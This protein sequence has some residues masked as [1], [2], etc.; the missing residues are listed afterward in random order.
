MSTYIT[1]SS[2]YP[3]N[4]DLLPTGSTSPTIS[5]VLDEIRDGNG[6][7]I[8]SGNKITAIEVNSIYT[9]IDKV[10]NVLGYNP[11]GSFADVS[12]RLNNMQFSGSLAFL[13]LSGG[14]IFGP[15]DFISGSTLTVTNMVGDNLTTI[16]SGN[17]NIYSSGNIGLAST[18]NLTISVAN[19]SITGLALTIAGSNVVMNGN[20]SNTL[21]SSVNQIVLTAASTSINSSIIPLTGSSVD[22]G[23]TGSF[24]NNLYV[25]NIISTG[26]G[27]GVN[28]YVTQSGSVMHGNLQFTGNAGIILT[29]GSNIT[30]IGSG[31]NNLGDSNNPFSGI[32][33]KVLHASFISGLSPVTFLSDIILNPGSTL[34]ASGTGV[35]IGSITN[36]IDTIYAT[37]IVGATGLDANLLVARSGSSMFGNLTIS[38]NANIVLNSGSNVTV[39]SSGNSNIGS[40]GSY[41]GNVYTNS[42]NNRPLG[43]M[44]FN[45]LMTGTTNGVNRTF[46]LSN[47]PASN[48]AMIFVSGLYTRPSVDYVFS[49]SAV[50]F[51]GSFAA[52][53]TAPYAGFYVY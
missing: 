33:T 52:P 17:T 42:I 39:V 7:V 18:G 20:A 45:E 13:H 16:L 49:G 40:T 21:S 38:G 43:T 34:T 9:I 53:T 41:I 35:V 10:E 51:T 14:N 46:W 26:I 3:S 19:A 11:E 2:N 30:N 50:V 48:F 6:V 36:P 15:V 28:G 5:Y 1:G 32:Y 29:T 44:V 24:I 8:Q 31:T 22:V 23:S 12:S 25:N 27:G 47:I 37:H 4:L